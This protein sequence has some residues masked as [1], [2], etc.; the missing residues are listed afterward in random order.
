MHIQSFQP[1]QSLNTFGIAVNA[2]HY[3]AVADAAQLFSLLTSGDS[4]LSRILVL[5]G[6][7]NLL[8]T[9][10]FDGLVLHMVNKGIEVCS[11]DDDMVLVR[12]AAGEVWDDFVTWSTDRSLYGIENLVAI[13]GSVGAAP[14]QNIGAYGME[15]SDTL[16]EVEVVMLEDGSS[17]TFSNGMCRFGYRSSIFKQE[18]KGQV[19][20]TS[21][22]F[23][24]KKR[25]SLNLSY[26]GVQ[27]V[28]QQRG[29]SHPTPADAAAAIRHIRDSKL[30]DP[31]VTGNA[32]SFFKNPVISA[33]EYGCLK[34]KFPNLP[35]YPQPDGT[36]KVAAGWLI[37]QS[38]LKGFRLGNAAVH[39]KQALVLVNAGGATGT[40]LVALANHVI[41]TVWLN[42][43]IR[44]EPE[45]NIL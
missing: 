23:R 2:A 38:G 29:L 21:V 20:I 31:A 3:L 27:E 36:V 22:T 37:E 15:L 43:G 30:P 32:G 25:G 10:D 28:L 18:L 42:Y 12:V 4:A 44:L 35:S 1:L 13:P 19:V 16:L 17:H 6:G 40:E 9:E 39:D 33:E 7:S 41:K 11:E 24:L 26:K 45:V 14:V 5:G 34:Q 8:F